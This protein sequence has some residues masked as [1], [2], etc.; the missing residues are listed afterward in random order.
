METARRTLS[1]PHL[2]QF[3]LTHSHSSPHLFQQYSYVPQQQYQPMPQQQ[4]QQQQYFS[5]QVL[6]LKQQPVQQPVQH[7]SMQQQQYFSPQAQSL[8]PQPVQAMPLQEQQQY[9]SP[10]Q[11]F[12]AQ[13]QTQTV[14]APQQLYFSQ[15][16]I[17]AL[18]PQRAGTP[19]PVRRDNIDRAA[20]VYHTP[21]VARHQQ[22]RSAVSPVQQQPL[23]PLGELG[24]R[25]SYY[26]TAADHREEPVAAA[27]EDPLTLTL[28]S[29]LVQSGEQP[30]PRG[31]PRSTK[32]AKRCMTRGLK[33]A[34]NFLA[35]MDEVDN[36]ETR[37]IDSEFID[38]ER[39]RKQAE[40]L[41]AARELQDK[42]QKKLHKKSYGGRQETTKRWLLAQDGTFQYLDDSDNE[43]LLLDGGDDGTILSRKTSNF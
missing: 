10:P 42:A 9:F 23:M 35:Q 2:A 3:Q 4:Q 33:S 7:Q 19:G 17:P 24:N 28:E 36:A 21:Q 40:E 39:E 8:R 15:H 20:L 13:P 31:T 6:P 18:Q 25:S 43:D 22:Q 29:T 34:F 32:R 30:V 37:Q 11:S 16:T 41:Q 38:D 5:P 1:S 12:V 14:A 27:V 26:N